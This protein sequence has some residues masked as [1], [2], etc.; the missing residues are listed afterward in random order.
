MSG[1]VAVILNGNGNAFFLKLLNMSINASWLILAVLVLRIF[2][3]KAP[4]W[5]SCLLWAVVAFRLICPISLESAFSLLPS[6]EV[7]PENIA[8]A[9]TPAI[10]SGIPVVNEI[11]NPVMARTMAPK[12]YESVNPMQALTAV[13]TLVW[14]VGVLTLSGYALA[15]YLLLKRRVSAAIQVEDGVMACDEI[16]TPFVLG[17]N[18]PVIYV[19]SHL[20]GET[21]EM[22]LSHERAHVQRHDHW[23]KPLGFAI[24]TVYWFQPLCLLAYVMLCRDIEAACD[25]KVIRDR[26]RE[27]AANYSQALLDLSAPRRMI[28][29]CPLAFGE[30]GVKERVKMVLHYKKPA[31][32][33]VCAG[34]A[35]AIVISVCF[36]TNPRVK[37]LEEQKENETMVAETAVEQT[38]SGNGDGET[39]AEKGTG[40]GSDMAGE[41]TGDAGGL[42]GEGTGDASDLVGK[43]NGGAV[44]LTDGELASAAVSDERAS[45]ILAFVEAVNER[46]IESYIALFTKDN[47]QE[48]RSFIKANGA[49]SFLAEPKRS[50]VKIEKT[51]I[52]PYEKDS[53]EFED[54]VVFR[55]TENIDF[56]DASSYYPREMVS[57]NVVHDY[58]IV[59]EEGEWKIYRISVSDLG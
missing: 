5:I 20:R 30:T 37:A 55:V 29:V 16:K 34:V 48:I 54:A 13:C 57:G 36:A 33:I 9:E 3:R 4:R 38:A 42:A 22:G 27:Y 8:V 44:G 21:L 26:D 1:A 45:L 25:E 50:I 28:T 18:R 32:W 39:L 49:D 17:L 6:G 11:V 12:A 7:I 58:V 46:D 15:S 47:Q 43:G 35:C 51:D 41:G 52:I 2:L 10:T 24:M 53:G 31:F 59:L 14:L 19:P 40:D 56:G 23:W